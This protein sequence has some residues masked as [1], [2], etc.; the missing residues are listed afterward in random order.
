MIRN[1]IFLAYIL[2]KTM[3]QIVSTLAS[4]NT[5]GRADAVMNPYK[6][7]WNP[8]PRLRATT[9]RPG[10]NPNGGSQTSAKNSSKNTSTSIEDNST[11]NTTNMAPMDAGILATSTNEGRSR[12][13]QLYEDFAQKHKKPRYSELQPPDV[14][15]KRS[16]SKFKESIL[17]FSKY[18][19]EEARQKMARIGTSQQVPSSIFQ[20]L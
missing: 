14:G 17:G 13:V 7:P 16:L 20:I 12:G 15:D 4:P 9:A 10:V 8:D 19:I 1:K 2:V 3:T 11:K 6:T 5:T 18:M